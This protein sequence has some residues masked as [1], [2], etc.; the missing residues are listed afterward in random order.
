MT[1]LYWQGPSA[2]RALRQLEWCGGSN[3]NAASKGTLDR[4]S[5]HL[6]S[7]ATLCC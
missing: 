5:A 1:S 3:S 2:R 6:R 4:S 7:L